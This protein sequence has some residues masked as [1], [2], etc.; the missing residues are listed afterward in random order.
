MIACLSVVFIH[1]ITRTKVAYELPDSTVTFYETIQ[2]MIMY[3]TPMFVLI[4]EVI[5]S[6]V[7]KESLPKRLFQEKT[8]LYFSAIYS[9][10]I[11]IRFILC[12]V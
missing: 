2:M 12:S 3:A 5:L 8:I 10:S 4:S 11:S 1:A 7:Y 9:H 6:H